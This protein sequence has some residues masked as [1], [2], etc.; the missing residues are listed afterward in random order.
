[1]YAAYLRESSVAVRGWQSS[2]RRQQSSRRSKPRARGREF[3]ADC[4]CR[5]CRAPGYARQEFLGCTPDACCGH[6]QERSVRRRN[7]RRAPD[8][9]RSGRSPR[10]SCVA[11]HRTRASRSAS[12][13]AGPPPAPSRGEVTSG[14]PHCFGRCHASAPRTSSSAASNCGEA[15]ASKACAC[16][17]ACR[18]RGSATVQVADAPCVMPCRR[19]SAAH[20][21]SHIRLAASGGKAPGTRVKPESSSSDCCCAVSTAVAIPCG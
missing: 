19:A 17:R 10:P 11:R 6:N 12:A 4:S 13:G 20:T 5:R 2:D 3:D 15:I 16:R 9:A 1:M 21:C 7:R 18:W 8:H 14:T